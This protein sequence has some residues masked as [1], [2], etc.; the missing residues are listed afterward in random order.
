MF[1][2]GLEQ[3]DEEKGFHSGGTITNVK[4]DPKPVTDQPA[5]NSST[6]A[7]GSWQCLP[8]VSTFIKSSANVTV[9]LQREVTKEL[10][11]TAEPVLNAG[12]GR[13]MTALLN[14]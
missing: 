7:S 9:V 1:A 5:T 6:L 11:V 14:T 13:K 8:A 12:G 10:A 3:L 4:E 2:D